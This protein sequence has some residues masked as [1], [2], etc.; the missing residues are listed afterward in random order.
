[1]HLEEEE[2][3]EFLTTTGLSNVPEQRNSPFSTSIATQLTNSSANCLAVAIAA[4]LASIIAA[5]FHSH[6]FCVEIAAHSVSLLMHGVF[7]PA[8]LHIKTLATRV[9]K[10]DCEV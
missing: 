4:L 3:D 9:L 8:F 5:V 10:K 6:A 7:L 1:M 2:G